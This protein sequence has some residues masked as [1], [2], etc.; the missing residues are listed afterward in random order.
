MNSAGMIWVLRNAEQW[1]KDLMD[2]EGQLGP[3]TVSAV[4][5]PGEEP[6]PELQ[7]LD[8]AIRKSRGAREGDGYLAAWKA[9]IE[10]PKPPKMEPISWMAPPWGE[11]E[12]WIA[13]M[14]SR[15]VARAYEDSLFRPIKESNGS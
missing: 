3:W 11:W 15:G 4:E 5:Y 12:S 9:R 2:R 7:R 6:C 8:L 10:W 13:R 1:L 14:M